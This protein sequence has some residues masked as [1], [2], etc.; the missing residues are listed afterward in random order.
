[1]APPTTLEL[2]TQTIE[3]AQAT[4]EAGEATVQEAKS[5]WNIT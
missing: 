3:Q 5:D 4:A 2:L 1:M